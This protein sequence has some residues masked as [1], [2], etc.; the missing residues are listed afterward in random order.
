[1]AG[2]AEARRARMGEG[3]GGPVDGHYSQRLSPAS[4]IP[5]CGRR[6]ACG[7][8]EGYRRCR[9]S[10]QSGKCHMKSRGNATRHR[11]YHRLM[12]P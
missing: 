4:M 7:E 6:N 2:P 10:R 11:V 1:M 12:G 8:D 3:G 5:V 9:L